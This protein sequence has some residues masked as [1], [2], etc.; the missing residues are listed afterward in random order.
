M[1]ELLDYLRSLQEG[2]ISDTDT[3]ETLLAACWHEFDGSDEEGMA[4]YKLHGRMERVEW[5]SPILSFTIERHG[6]TAMGSTRATLQEWSVD[7]E[8]RTAGFVSSGYRQVGAMAPR[9]YVR[10]IAE[11][12]AQLIIAHR[13]DEVLKWYEDGSVRVHIGKILPEGFAFKQTLQGRRKRFRQ[14][15]EEILLDAGWTR[16]RANVYAPPAK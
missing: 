1:Q 3:L 7:V 6:G 14:A 4:G 15:L 2:R 16:I 12:I 10:P 5:H 13:E 9:V 11:E 8:R